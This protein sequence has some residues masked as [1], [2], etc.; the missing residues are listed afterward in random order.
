MAAQLIAESVPPPE[1]RGEEAIFGRYLARTTC[2]H[3]HGADLRGG[4]NPE[5]TSPSLKV[6]AAYSAESFAKLLRTGV[7]PG[8]R[9]LATMGAVAREHFSLLTDPE[10]AAL[11]NY[12]HGLP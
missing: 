9:K 1:A 7:P 8:E 2:S 5:F 10:I 12:L 11:Y 6:V 4:S 3:C